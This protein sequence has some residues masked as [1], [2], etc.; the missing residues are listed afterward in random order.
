[1]KLKFIIFGVLLCSSI[2]ASAQVATKEPYLT[3]TALFSHL[4]LKEGDSWVLK[5]VLSFNRYSC[6]TDEYNY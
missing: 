1:M 2:H 3:S 4:W 6:V 5:R